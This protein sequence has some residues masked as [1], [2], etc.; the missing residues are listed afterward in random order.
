MLDYFVKANGH[1]QLIMQT[2]FNTALDSNQTHI[3]PLRQ[4]TRA[5]KLE[6][7]K[8]PVILICCDI[9]GNNIS[10]Q[11]KHKAFV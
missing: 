10:K 3:V 1:F 2:T 6:R 7:A 8:Q 5:Q 11:G 9:T 4:N